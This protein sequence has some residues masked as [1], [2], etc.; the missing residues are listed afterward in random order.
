M[1]FASKNDDGIRVHG[2]QGFPLRKES[3]VEI[4]GITTEIICTNYSDKIMVNISQ[5]DKFGSIISAFSE[6]TG[7]SG[8]LYHIQNLLGRRDDP[9]LNI[10]A[11]QIIENISE[12]SDKPLILTISLKD[13]GRSSVVF[14]GVM[15]RLLVI[16]TW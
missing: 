16:R 6:T 3:T 1:E 2:E 9:L 12:V 15:N 14:H 7:E 5:M 10:Y 8:K 11:R 13:E 4:D